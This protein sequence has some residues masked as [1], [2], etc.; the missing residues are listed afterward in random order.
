MTLLFIFVMLG[1]VIAG[2]AIIVLQGGSRKVR[3]AKQSKFFQSL[4]RFLSQFFITQ[5]FIARVYGKLANLSIYRRTEL[6]VLSV[7]YF[8][9]SWGLSGLVLFVSFFL[10]RD[11][12]T[13][14]IVVLFALLLTNIVV[15]KQLDL[16]NLKVMKSLSKLLGSI[17][18]EYLRTGSV[19]ESLSDAECDD[20]LKKPLDDIVAILTAPNGELKLQEFCEATPYRTIQTLAGICYH[21]HNQGDEKDAY[22]QSNF[23][24]ALTLLLSDVNA[25]I[26]KTVYRRKRFGKIEY[27]PIVPIIGIGAIEPYFMSI[28]P[29]TAL[30]YNGPLGYLM[31][32]LTV[33]SAVICYS[34]VSRVNCDTPF[35][36]DDRNEYISALLDK[37][38][39]KR[40][41]RN[42]SPR[43]KSRMKVERNLKQALSRMTVEHLYAKKVFSGLIAICL[44]FLTAFTTISLGRD[45]ILTSTQEL[46]LV[47]ST[48]KSEFE[49]NAIRQMDAVYLANPESF[50]RQQ[51]ETLVRSSLPGL[52][53]LQ[54]QDQIKRLEMKKRSLD[55]AYFKWWYTWICFVVG[56][57]GWFSPNIMLSIRKTLVQ[58]EEEEDFMQ[59]QTLVSILM[60]TNI[61]TLDMLYELSQHSRV[62]KDMFIYAY[63]G[64][65]SN[66]ELE[67]TRL[68]SKTPIIEFKRFIGKMKMT[69]SDLSL[70]EAYSDLLIERDHMLKIRDMTLT[71]SINRKRAIC[72]PLS[73]VPLG[74]FI[75]GEF[76]I[77]IGILGYNEFMNAL[78]N[79]M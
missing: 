9:I 24:Q 34:I 56:I 31:R 62:H 28:M 33:L 14:L 54:V 55:N 25:A 35:K 12:L 63:Q 59:L 66:P 74:I 17:R 23:N 49:L 32:T 41:I 68:Q 77:P 11:I 47:A 72:G 2:V 18:Q 43:N 36:V 58:T 69:I 40:F 78:Q 76:I 19:L 5:S 39:F 20:L 51:L 6:Q 52:S 44:A 60:N 27:L 71:E 73:M 45:F 4:Y 1:L 37:S 10:F 22:G 67:L 21:I 42:I 53:D 8:L 38:F 15:D 29:G 48:N 30:I 61:D 70:K 16:M 57:I 3:Q 13:T 79:M 50:N 65:P 75:L 64:Y 26:Q 7:K 46:S